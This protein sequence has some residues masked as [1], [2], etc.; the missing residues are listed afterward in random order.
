[1]TLSQQ[2]GKPHL[3][4]VQ[5]RLYWDNSATTCWC[6][7]RFCSGTGSCGGKTGGP[8][9]N[10]ELGGDDVKKRC[11]AGTKLAYLDGRHGSDDVQHWRQVLRH[12]LLK[13]SGLCFS[14]LAEWPLYEGLHR[15]W[16]IWQ[17]RAKASAWLVNDPLVD[18]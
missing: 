1:M 12:S 6:S 16:D 17:G 3:H 4:R 5:P 13:P 18:L 11:T 15:A 14:R 10:F 2:Q 9:C 7:I 8:T